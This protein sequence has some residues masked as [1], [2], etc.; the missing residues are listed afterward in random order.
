[1]NRQVLTQEL[2]NSI[3][4]ITDLPEHFYAALLKGRAPLT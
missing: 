1:M 4:V 3:S 2:T